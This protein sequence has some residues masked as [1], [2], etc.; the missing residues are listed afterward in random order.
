MYDLVCRKRIKNTSPYPR[1]YW[2]WN[3]ST[4]WNKTMHSSACE[5]AEKR[6]EMLKIPHGKEFI[7]RINQADNAE[8]MRQS[9]SNDKFILMHREDSVS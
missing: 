6:Y 2:P 8:M 3:V 5:F 4:I 1:L 9:I 7:L